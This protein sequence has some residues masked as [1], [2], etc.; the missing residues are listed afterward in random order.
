M[1]FYSDH[2]LSSLL[3]GLSKCVLK[4]RIEMFEKENTFIY[5][6][7][8]NAIINTDGIAY[9]ISVVQTGT[10]KSRRSHIEMFL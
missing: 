9:F 6:F 5:L 8:F 1:L 10:G 2:K 7:Y 4:Q 3:I